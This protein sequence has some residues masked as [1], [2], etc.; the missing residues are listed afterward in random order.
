MSIHMV[1]VMRKVSV[2]PIAL[3]VIALLAYTARAE[4][5]RPTGW[6]EVVP[7]GA[8]ENPHLAYDGGPG[9]ST[10]HCRIYSGGYTE[11]VAFYFYPGVILAD[12]EIRYSWLSN[13]CGQGIECPGYV[14]L[15]AYNWTSQ[16][17]QH[18]RLKMCDEVLDERVMGLDPPF[19]APDGE[20]WVRFDAE[21]G[22]N[23]PGWGPGE[24]PVTLRLYDV[25]VSGGITPVD[26]TTWAAIKNLFHS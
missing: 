25:Y 19:I 5:Y 14:V 22:R 15:S 7:D 8:L 9:E 23:M 26:D 11:A 24:F 21:C 13:G 12:P 6:S 18:L 17:W 16:A 2:L 3:V 20:V 1:L 10:T 4:S